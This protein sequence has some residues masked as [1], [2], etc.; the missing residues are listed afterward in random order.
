[1]DTRGIVGSPPPEIRVSPV[2]RLSNHSMYV[3]SPESSPPPF[4]DGVV[5]RGSLNLRRPLASARPPLVPFR[6]GRANKDIPATRPSWLG[7]NNTGE[8]GEM[9]RLL[10]EER[11]AAAA[12]AAKQT[13]MNTQYAIQAA[14][15][16]KYIPAE[17]VRRGVF[18]SL[19]S[20]GGKR[21]KKTLKRRKTK[22]NRRRRASK[23]R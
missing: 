2:S 17:S 16:A 21:Q 10:Q 15:K 5:P 11:N 3:S 22:N 23:T 20:T 12:A 14:E 4:P 9:V 13:N 6:M 7:P 1:M 19:T 18:K 8:N